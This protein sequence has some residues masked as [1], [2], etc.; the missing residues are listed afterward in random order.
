MNSLS[1]YLRSVH[2]LATFQMEA[3]QFQIHFYV[4]N[5][6]SLIFSEGMVSYG[7]A[8]VLFLFMFTSVLQNAPITLNYLVSSMLRTA[9]TSSNVKTNKLKR[10]FCKIAQNNCI[11]CVTLK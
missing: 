5:D 1:D 9:A 7:H 11:K 6:L 10:K 4:I 2:F 3:L 8:A